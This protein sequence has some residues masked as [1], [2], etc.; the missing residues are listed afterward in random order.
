MPYISDSILNN[1]KS[2]V[3]SAIDLIEANP[4]GSSETNI[5]IMKYLQGIL[6]NLK[7]KTASLTFAS[8]KEAL[9]HL[10]NVT[11]KKIKVA[12]DPNFTPKGGKYSGSTKGEMETELDIDFDFQF[13]PGHPELP[14]E[15]YNIK[16]KN[17][18]LDWDDLSKGDKE[19]L[20]KKAQ[21]II[22]DQTDKNMAD[23]QDHLDAQKEEVLI[24]GE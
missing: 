9:Q 23:Y 7:G 11:G 24:R 19:M 16:I 4:E 3:E 15:I 12:A 18:T 17:N 1:I 22:D 21:E 10:A 20:M 14:I 2:G 5:D 13:S 6:D 8:E